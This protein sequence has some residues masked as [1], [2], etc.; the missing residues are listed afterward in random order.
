VAQSR[1]ILVSR[2]EVGEFIA[3]CGMGEDGWMSHFR[4]RAGYCVISVAVLICACSRR[5][6]TEAKPTAERFSVTKLDGGPLTTYAPGMKGL[7][8][9]VLGTSLRRTFIILNDPD[10]PIE[11][12]TWFSYR[13]GSPTSTV[14]HAA[15]QLADP[16]NWRCA[17]FL[18]DY[19]WSIKARTPVAAWEIHN[20]EFDAVN[21]YLWD[22]DMLSNTQGSDAGGLDP[23]KEQK[24]G[25]VWWWNSSQTANLG[26]WLTSV[27]F[28]DS[29]RTKDGK[30]WRCG[31]EGLV[32][33]MKVL[34]FEIP[35]E[36]K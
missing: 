34:S 14:L 27:A 10:S 29:V 6:S 31:K 5:G 26:K 12:V 2:I 13:W 16:T 7:M 19:D 23:G 20:A 3:C 35:P 8:K 36:L 33:Q 1:A 9:P 32:A 15:E 4:A 30:I 28:V 22:H 17:T 11:I 18:Y 25:R 21:H 24:T